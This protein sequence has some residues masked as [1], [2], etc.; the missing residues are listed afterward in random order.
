MTYLAFV[1]QSYTE[2]SNHIGN[3]ARQERFS[4]VV[5]VGISKKS[6]NDLS[7]DITAIF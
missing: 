4:D 3:K 5:D 7:K 1:R 6:P 2:E